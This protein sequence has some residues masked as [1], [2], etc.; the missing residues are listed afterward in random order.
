MG[1]ESLMA[2]TLAENHVHGIL[3]IPTVSR[4]KN[5]YLPQELMK[6]HGRRIPIFLDHEDLETRVNEFGDR[7]PTGRRLPL[8]PRGEATLLWNSK[9]NQL[10]YNGE[11]WDKEAIRRVKDEGYDKVSLAGDPVEVEPFHGLNVPLGL[12]FF[13][14]SMVPDPG[15]PHTSMNMAAESL[16]EPAG[17]VMAEPVVEMASRRFI[18]MEGNM[19][20]SNQPPMS[21][22]AV[23]D[24]EPALAQ[25]NAQTRQTGVGI[26][27]PLIATTGVAPVTGVDKDP[28]LGGT[29]AVGVSGTANVTP[30]VGEPLS[31][32]FA[33]VKGNM[34]SQYGDKADSVYYG[35]LNKN[36]YDDK[37]AFP[38]EGVMCPHDRP[39]AE[40]AECNAA[41]KKEGFDVKEDNDQK[42]AS[43][44]KEMV[45]ATQPAATTQT[46]KVA[47]GDAS[48]ALDKVELDKAHAADPK[49]IGMFHTPYEELQDKVIGGKATAEESALYARLTKEKYVDTR[50]MS[51]LAVGN[52]VSGIAAQE[53]NADDEDGAM[54]DGDEKKKTMDAEEKMQDYGYTKEDLEE[55]FK[56]STLSK[57]EKKLAVNIFETNRAAQMGAKLEAVR[58]PGSVSSRR[59][60]KASSL[61]ES[62]KTGGAG[63]RGP[64][65]VNGVDLTFYETEKH[66]NNVMAETRLSLLDPP[67]VV[68]GDD[69]W[70]ARNSWVNMIE[71]Y[72]K[73]RGYTVVSEAIATTTSGAAMGTLANQPALIVPK[74]L[75]A[76]LRDTC[77]FQQ[78]PEGYKTIAF[79]AVTVPYAVALTENTEPSQASQTLT[80]VSVTPTPRGLEQQL[81]FE[82][83][84]KIMGPIMEGIILSFRVAELY[85]EDYLLVGG[86]NTPNYGTPASQCF[87]TNVVTTGTGITN[88]TTGNQL[89]GGAA[90]GSAYNARASEATIIST[91][92]MDVEAID[93]GINQ[94]QLQGYSTDNAVWVGHPAQYRKLLIDSNAIRMVSFGPNTDNGRSMLAQGVIPEIIGAELRRSTLINTGTGSASVTTY[95]S[96]IYKKG[97]TVGLGASRDL[98][99]ETFRDIRANSIW[100]KAHWDMVAQLLQPN[101]LIELVTA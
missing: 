11:V 18:V 8:R 38:K 95:H 56:W 46:K 64:Y 31:P 26:P 45:E 72:G 74:N 83:D 76:V 5:F 40:C 82:A 36:G 79:Q 86:S 63:G 43:S 2:A 84:R 19:Q 9:M 32:D 41:M 54:K 24:I 3:A 78:V 28:H 53:T 17:P 87:E 91:D 6:A 50:S 27:S 77:Y 96:W 92:T 33:K 61:T 52:R 39:F 80:T 67:P 4:N 60:S 99:I 68:Y 88:Q 81:S 12:N 49:S 16:S 65:I 93:N 66:L 20:L 94:L 97:L 1:G 75:A 70:K 29:G 51:N 35:W 48:S 21:R 62:G 22:P 57:A 34:A 90:S 47:E 71:S 98:M 73:G 42:A 59:E 58:D 13:S 10:E 23:S 25:Q 7:V 30:M 14:M 89:F 37:K 15:I 69:A 100:V 85:D 55:K 44:K 101:S